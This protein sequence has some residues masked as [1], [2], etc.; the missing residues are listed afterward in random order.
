M[1]KYYESNAHFQNNIPL[2]QYTCGNNY[3]TPGRHPRIPQLECLSGT[4]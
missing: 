1:S 2:H 4:L 3:A